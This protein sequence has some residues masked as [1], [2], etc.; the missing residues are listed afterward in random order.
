MNTKFR[1]YLINLS[2]VTGIILLISAGA[3]LTVFKQWFSLIFPFVILYFFLLNSIQHHKLLKSSEKNPRV[4][5]TNYMAWFGIKLFLNLTFIL[6]YVLLNRAEAL[7][8]VLFFGFCYLI[9][10]T[11]EVVALTKTLGSGNVK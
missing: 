4:F 1:K 10:T 11:Y 9:Y 5:H 3:F 8:F 7:S 2:I 6:I